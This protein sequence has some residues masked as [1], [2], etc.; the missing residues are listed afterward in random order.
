MAAPAPAVAAATVQEGDRYR[1]GSAMRLPK[2][3]LSPFQPFMTAHPFRIAPLRAISLIFTNGVAWPMRWRGWPRIDL[4]QYPL[5]SMAHSSRE[6]H[7]VIRASWGKL[8]R[9]KHYAGRRQG[10]EWWRFRWRQAKIRNPAR[11][12][13]ASN[14]GIERAKRAGRRGQG[15]VA[16]VSIKATIHLG[17]W[18][19]TPTFSRCRSLRNIRAD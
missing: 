18:T 6:S 4:P 1:P 19:P 12:R 7:G 14:P 17:H 8:H 16:F 5:P 15:I 10:R 13:N 2:T 9:R 11:G 3:R